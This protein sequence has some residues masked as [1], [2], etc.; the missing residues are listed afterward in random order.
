VKSVV[1]SPEICAYRE[2][3]EPLYYG[4]SWNV[5]AAIDGLLVAVIFSGW[6]CV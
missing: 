4:E 2:D 6:G 5:T 3:F 1:S